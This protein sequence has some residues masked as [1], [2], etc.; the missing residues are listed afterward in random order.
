MGPSL[1]DADPYGLV[2]SA[3]GKKWLTQ[4]GAWAD[5]QIKPN[6]YQDLRN[7]IVQETR[8]ED[9][10]IDPRMIVGTSHGRYNQGMTWRKFLANGKRISTKLDVFET[11][12]EYYDDPKSYATDT[13]PWD[14]DEINGELYTSTGNH[15]SVV[16]KFRAHEEGRIEQRVWAVDRMMVSK[17]AQQQYAELQDEYLPTERDWGPERELISEDGL[18]KEYRIF[19]NCYLHGLN[20]RFYKLPLAEAGAY[21]RKKNRIG[22]TIFNFAPSIWSRLFS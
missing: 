20:Q 3:I 16:A 17:V 15:R 10:I 12:S 21:V 7:F 22:K 14:F 2:K 13:E 9:C 11:A 1:T 4:S 19:V 6:P 18:T 5:E 8:V